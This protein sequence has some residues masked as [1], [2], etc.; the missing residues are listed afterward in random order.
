MHEMALC[1]AIVQMLEDQAKEHAY[2]RV[3]RVRLSVGP[4]SCVEPEALQFSFDACTRGTLADGASLEILNAEGE[5]WCFACSGAFAVTGHG[6]AC[7]TCGSHQ[8]QITAGDE[9]KVKEME[10]V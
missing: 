8:V 2:T 10:V 4:L 7:P 5:A 1:E 3:K 9:F 6:Q